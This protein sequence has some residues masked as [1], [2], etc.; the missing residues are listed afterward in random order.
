MEFV[1]HLRMFKVLKI[2]TKKLQKKYTD[3][4]FQNEPEI[5]YAFYIKYNTYLIQKLTLEKRLNLL[6]WHAM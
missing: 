3:N 2:T 4:P 1:H 5:K 6:E